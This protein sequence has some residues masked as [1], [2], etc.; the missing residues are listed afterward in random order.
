MNR[1]ATRQPAPATGDAGPSR[2][3][4]ALGA[5]I[6]ALAALAAAPP[7][8]LADRITV[9][10]QVVVHR[11]AVT[12]ADLATLD[13]PRAH[14]L[15][16]VEV[17]R[18]AADDGATIQLDRRSLRR[19]LDARGVNWGFLSLRGHIATAIHRRGAAAD[20]DAANEAGPDRD[21]EARGRSPRPDAATNMAT[22]DAAPAAAEPALANPPR[23]AV[24]VEGGSAPPT[25]PR[26]A[27]SL[28]Q[29][30]V[31]WIEA[32]SGIDADALRIDW[33]R[34]PDDLRG[35]RTATGRI[36]LDPMSRDALGRLP[37][38][39]RHY[40]AGRLVDTHR[41]MLDVEAS[42]PVLVAAS[43][44]SRGQTLAREDL[45]RRVERIDSSRLRPL[46]AIDAAVG[47]TAARTLRP[48]DILEADDVRPPDLVRR[49]QRV[50]VRA[51]SGG[52]V[53]KTVARAMDDGRMDQVIR[54]RHPRSREVFHARVTGPQQAA[55]LLGEK[56]DPRSAAP[57]DAAD[58]DSNHG[59]D[60]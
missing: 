42:L 8:L 56:N 20:A 25:N 6:L 17:A 10:P 30:V 55:M 23:Q 3:G 5:L 59:G 35:L 19:I 53:L 48:G 50:T 7:N 1:H 29:R 39:V 33:G 14:A 12:L 22:N 15:A 32:R 18:F 38:K 21:A 54:L 51:L 9:R 58:A 27:R 16:D 36:E 45:E 26:D 43:N 4:R 13:G 41:L 28:Q 44:I 2:A 11:D 31:E 37:F 57:A 47:Q 40:E 34:A 46:D 49:G 52:L 60:S 24:S